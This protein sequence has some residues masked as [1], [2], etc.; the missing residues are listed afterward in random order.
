MSFELGIATF[1][2][3]LKLHVLPVEWT[4]PAVEAPLLYKCTIGEYFDW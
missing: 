2:D 4:L 1:A 3:L